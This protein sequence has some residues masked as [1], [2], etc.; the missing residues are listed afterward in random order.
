MARS[1]PS[2]KSIAVY[3]SNVHFWQEAKIKSSQQNTKNQRNPDINK[4]SKKKYLSMKIDC[5]DPW[6]F[7]YIMI[8]MARKLMRQRM[9]SRLVLK[10]LY[11]RAKS[12]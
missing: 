7:R 9:Y 10:L 5:L 8:I 1:Y 12:T 3:L 2:V 11:G 6:I 4:V